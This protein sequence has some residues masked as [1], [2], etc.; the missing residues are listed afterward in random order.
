MV[1]Q[2]T[3]RAAKRVWLR[4]LRWPAGILLGLLLALY[5]ILPLVARPILR[6]KL[7]NMV[8]SQLDAELQIARVSYV[9][10]YGV[11][12]HDATLTTRRAGRAHELL[13]L[14]AISLELAKLPF[15]DGPL[16]VRKIRLERPAVHLVRTPD[17]LV[18]RHLHRPAPAT[19]PAAATPAAEPYKLSDMFELRLVEIIKGQVVYDDRTKAGAVPVVWRDIDVRL[20]TTPTD[21]PLYAFDFAA[22]NARLATIAAGGTFDIDA[23]NLTLAKLSMQVSADPDAA[24]SPAPA[25]VQQVIRQ[26]GIRGRLSLDARAV[27]PLKDLPSTTLDA[28]LTLTDARAAARDLDK[29]SLVTR[30]STTPLSPAHELHAT[31]VRLRTG[32]TPPTTVAT[33]TPAAERPPALYVLVKDLRAE[34]S[35]SVATLADTSI[36]FDWPA[37]RW[38]LDDLRLTTRLKAPTPT[39]SATRPTTA[40]VPLEGDISLTA[41]GA[42]ELDAPF[43]RSVRLKLAAPTLTFSERRLTMADVAADL[44]L[45]R[46]S[47]TILN[48]GA[49]AT[50]Y[51]GAVRLTGAVFFGREPRYDLTLRWHGADLQ[52]FARDW[53][54]PGDKP[55]KLTGRGSLASH[56]H[57]T[58]PT[59]PWKWTDSLTM[60]GEFA[61]KNGDFFDLPGL[62]DI[63][64]STSKSSDAA[65]VGQAAGVFTLKNRQI[66]F[67]KIAISAPVLGLQ[68]S[69]TTTLEGDQMDFRAVAAP[70]AD[71]KRNLKKTDVPIVS[72]V[73]GEV[74][75]GIQ[76]MLNATSGK[77]LYQFHITGPLKDPRVK[78]EPAP[79]LTDG[80][81]K[82]FAEMLKGSDDLLEKLR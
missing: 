60:Q 18:G 81:L 59:K 10:P 30:L 26:Q 12:V 27:I 9:F 3:G 28:T 24:D 8:R 38:H 43:E 79:A 33:T 74:A 45:T 51:E 4:R 25:S 56:F 73:L 20:T 70:L 37:M 58:V 22:N 50:A 15:G 53:P 67:T 35:T 7:Q 71:W 13:K 14:P 47:V 23:L 31:A 49:R 65:R 39:L 64:R 61:I 34:T 17:G 5:V 52:E 46:E 62:T 68:G 48:D 36:A 54:K 1:E 16:V 78:T 63:V 2:G 77:L 80:A 66:H 6:A 32:R 29:L 72:E 19:A 57:G 44:Q 69:G 40:G 42:G 11:K 41:S 75:G 55:L 76:S 82:L 21:N